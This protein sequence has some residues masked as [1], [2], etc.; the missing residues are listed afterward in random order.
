MID[1]KY[2]EAEIQSLMAQRDRVVS[3]ANGA[4]Q[5]Y[6]ALIEKM[7]READDQDD[8]EPR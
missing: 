2:L 5:A 7:K 6:A 8:A 3:E 1:V 4:I